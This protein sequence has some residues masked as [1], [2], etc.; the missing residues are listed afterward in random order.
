MVMVSPNASSPML[1][2]LS[3]SFTMVRPE[4]SL[5]ADPPMVFT[6]SGMVTEVR[7]VPLKTSRPISS[8]LSGIV[9]DASLRQLAKA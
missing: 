3:G 6:L 7:A 1:F 4:Q 9:T 5:K 2:T 8:T